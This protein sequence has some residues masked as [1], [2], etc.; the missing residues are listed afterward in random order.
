MRITLYVS[1]LMLERKPMMTADY[2]GGNRFRAFS[3]VAEFDPGP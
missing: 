3:G 2:P 1:G